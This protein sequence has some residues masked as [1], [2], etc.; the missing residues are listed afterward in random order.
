MLSRKILYIVLFLVSFSNV[1]GQLNNIWVI[2]YNSSGIPN[3]IN[4]IYSIDFR[5][6][7]IDYDTALAAAFSFRGCDA[8][9][10]DS[11]GNLLFYTNGLAVMNAQ[12]D[13]M[14]NGDSLNYSDEA[15]SSGGSL[16]GMS[17]PQTILILP[18]PGQPD[19]YYLIHQAY[20][21]HPVL[22]TN[23]YCDTLFY[24]IV[25]MSQDSGKGAV[26]TKNQVLWSGDLLTDN[27]ITIGGLSACK[28]AN[29]RDWWLVTHKDSSNVFMKFLLT[30]TGIAGPFLQTIYPFVNFSMV[31]A[32]FS[33]DGTKFAFNNKSGVHLFNFDRCTGNFS[34]HENLGQFT[35]P[36]YGAT[37]TVF[38]PNSRVLYASGGF[39][40]YQW[41]LN[42]AN[43]QSTRTTVCVYD[44]T[45]TCPS[46]GVFFYLMQRAINGK[47]YVSSPNSSSCFSV[48][49][50]PDVVGPG[51]NAI[52][53][54]LSDLP[55]YNGSSVPYF[56]DFDLGAIPGSNCDSLTALTNPPSQPQNF[57]IYPNPAQNIL[58]IAYTG[59]S[60]I[61]S[62]YLQLVDITGKVILKRA[63]TSDELKLNLSEIENGIYFV[64]LNDTQNTFAGKVLIQ[65]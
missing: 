48:I 25:D 40:I 65:H 53:H 17:Y 9:I 50:N 20:Y 12:H 58:N 45:Y 19:M 15:Y 11:A 3:P 64:I 51:C 35:L 21:L 38:S 61:T 47:I 26:V 60:D 22:W 16:T 49:N 4:S 36:T 6:G 1:H 33:P 44:S 13:T 43:V 23:E 39:E 30:P 46:Y 18:S 59:N 5:N 42:A 31:Q 7:T 56:P 14:V 57:E 28:H 29:G 2:G 32:C 63:L 8:S 37:G 24:S 27:L 62:C 10:C 34:A 54:G 41:D 52:A 55:Y